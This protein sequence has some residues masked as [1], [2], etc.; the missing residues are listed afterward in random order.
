MS[1]DKKPRE[2]SFKADYESPMNDYEQ[3][4]DQDYQSDLQEN[5]N[6]DHSV[7]KSFSL[8]ARPVE[9]ESDPAARRHELIQRILKDRKIG[10]GK[11]MKA[12]AQKYQ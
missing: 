3:E 10:M 2:L 7:D 4:M 12:L 8:R 6:M 5:L 9:E 1:A 11:D